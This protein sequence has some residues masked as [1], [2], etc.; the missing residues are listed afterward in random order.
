MTGESYTLYTLS[1]ASREA[2]AGFPMPRNTKV[3]DPT[4]RGEGIVR[5]DDITLDPRYGHNP[6]HY[7]KPQ[8]PSAGAQLPRRTGRVALGRGAWRPVLRPLRRS[9]VFTERDEL[10]AGGIAA[11]AAIA[12]DN[13]RLY[14]AS[15]QAQESLRGSSTRALEQR[16]ADEI[17]ERMRAEEA[18]RQAQKMEAVGQL[19]GGVAH[20]FNNLLTAI[21]G[22]ADTLQRVAAD[23]RRR[24]PATASGAPC[25]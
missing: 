20:D 23:R 22:G 1:G 18:L 4:F 25:A 19:T 17:A 14:R 8:R 7:G 6:P 11:Q 24:E 21:C 13:A 5:S 3:F 16:V 9:R 10:I 2:F 15:R 12:I